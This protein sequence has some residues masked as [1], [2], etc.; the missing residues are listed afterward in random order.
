MPAKPVLFPEL[1]KSGS[2]SEEKFLLGDT[3]MDIQGGDIH[4]ISDPI[5]NDGIPESIPIDLG[6]KGVDPL[7]IPTN[8]QNIEKTCLDRNQFQNVEGLM[9]EVVKE[10]DKGIKE[11]GVKPAGVR[12]GILVK[13]RDPE[14]QRCM[15]MYMNINMCLYILVFE[16]LCQC[17]HALMKICIDTHMHSMYVCNKYITH[18]VPPPPSPV[19]LKTVEELAHDMGLSPE[20]VQSPISIEILKFIGK[21]MMT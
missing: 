2:F 4:K 11:K 10:S 1:S 14:K 7:C 17:I 3:L 8:H 9:A 12:T 16:Y 21:V 20:C 15:Y 5:T 19:K 13:D 18:V 6:T